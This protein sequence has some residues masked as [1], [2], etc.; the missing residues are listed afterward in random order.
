VTIVL[1]WEGF[2]VLDVVVLEVA[3]VVA[4]KVDVCV[5]PATED[6]DVPAFCIVECARKAERKLPKNGLFVGI[7][8][9]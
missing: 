4:V 2:A 3:F 9:V 8:I 6:G 5:E 1:L 7:S